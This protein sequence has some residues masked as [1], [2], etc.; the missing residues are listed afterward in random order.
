MS[1]VCWSGIC[2]TLYFH[3]W[4][5]S[6]T[7]RDAKTS[8]CFCT[9]T[10]FRGGVVIVRGNNSAPEVSATGATL[11]MISSSRHCSWNRPTRSAPPTGQRFCHLRPLSSLHEQAQ[12]LLGQNEYRQLPTLNILVGTL[13]SHFPRFANIFSCFRI[14]S[15][16]VDPIAMAP[17]WAMNSG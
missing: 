8:P 5:V 14:H 12:Y 16:V 13:Y 10:N 1:P 4:V 2:P 11:R 6:G 15:Y 3:P 17:T 7:I 9:S